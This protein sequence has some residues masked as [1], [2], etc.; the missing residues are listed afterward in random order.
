MAT[1]IALIVHSIT[2]NYGVQK[3]QMYEQRMIDNSLRN[4]IVSLLIFTFSLVACNHINEEEMENYKPKV[5]A[6]A[7]PVV[8]E[9]D[10]DPI[11]WDDEDV[12]CFFLT[13]G[14]NNEQA[15]RVSGQEQ[16]RSS[17]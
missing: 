6:P 10:E 7:A 4:T 8:P 16:G 17:S 14:I 12:E 9:H 2:N 15:W 5:I 11:Y 1:Y 13:K 3:Q